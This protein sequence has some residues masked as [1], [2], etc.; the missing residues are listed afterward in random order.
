M[1]LFFLF[2]GVLLLIANAFFVAIE[3]CLV[4]TSPAAME[5]EVAKGNRRALRAMES[6]TD[7]ARQVAGAQLGITM[8]SL[9]LGIIAEP[10]LEHYVEIVLPFLDEGLRHTVAAIIAL[11]IVVFLHLMLGEMVPKNLALAGPVRTTVWLVP[12]HRVF[13]TLMSPV[14]WL[15]DRIATVIGGWL[16]AERVDERVQARTPAEL[17]LLL[18]DTRGGGVID[19]FEHS[20]LSGALEL[21]ESDVATVMVPWA[22]VATVAR[23]ATIDE[24][25][26]AVVATGHS[27]LPV[28][29]AGKDT[30]VGWLH[31][32]DLLATLREMNCLKLQL[33]VTIMKHRFIQ[34]LWKSVMALMM[35]VMER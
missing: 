32:K 1:N 34:I 2:L 27:R 23:T 21:G 3:F 26:S 16:G 31:A 29:A 35:I 33:T 11:A 5:L 20:L 4:A 12:I 24:V 25:D 6:F 30:P 14:I 7:I 17:L 18:D 28:L 9:A 8:A 19:D 15:L 22:D 13:V 10:A